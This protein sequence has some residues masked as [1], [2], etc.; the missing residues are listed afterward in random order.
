MDT[1]EIKNKEQTERS[2]KRKDVEIMDIQ[3]FKW[4]QQKVI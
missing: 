1:L 2:N 3:P 4:V